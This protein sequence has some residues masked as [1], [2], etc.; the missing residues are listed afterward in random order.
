MKKTIFISTV[1]VTFLVLALAVTAVI[2][3]TQ[4]SLTSLDNGWFWGPVTSVADANNL[5]EQVVVLEGKVGTQTNVSWNE[6]SFSDSTG[7]TTLDFEDWITSDGIPQNVTVRVI[8]EAE[9]GKIDVFGLQTQGT[10]TATADTTA[11]QI[12]SGSKED[13]N[14]VLQGQIGEK[15]DDPGYWESWMWYEFTDSSGTT[16]VDLENKLSENQVPQNQT[17]LLYGSGDD[18]YGDPKVNIDYILLIGGGE[19]PPTATET[20]P[21]PPPTAT[22]T[23]QPGGDWFWEK[24]HTVS[25]AC[26]LDQMVAVVEGQV[27]NRTNVSWNEWTFSDSSGSLTLDFEDWIPTAAIPQNTTV[28]IIGKAQDCKLD[29]WGLQTQGKVFVQPDT[30]AAQINTGNYKNQEV[31]LMGQIGDQNSTNFPSSWN[32]YNFADSSGIT[33]TDLENDLTAS[34]IPQHLTMLLFGEGNDYFGDPKVDSDY[35]LLAATDQPVPTATPTATNTLPGPA[36]TA[37][38]TPV[39]GEVNDLNLPIVVS[40]F[41]ALPPALPTKTPIPTPTT[42]PTGW[43]WGPVTTVSQLLSGCCHEQVVVVQG[44]IGNQTDVPWNEWSFSDGTGTFTLD[45]E[46]EIPKVAIPRDTTVQIIGR[47]E[48]NQ[49]GIEKIDVYGLQTKGNVSATADTT[50]Q[51]VESGSKD[52]QFIA[53]EGQFGTQDYGP[54]MWYNFSDST[55]TTIADLENALTDSQIPKNQT[56]LLYGQGDEDF[57]QNKINAK[58]MLFAANIK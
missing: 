22:N 31:I 9:N 5:D 43:L 48:T 28:H 6:W 13:Q 26:S 39:P 8:G 44:Q 12:N 21:G 20:Q 4:S 58:L 36:P 34:Q 41:G 35:M 2:A 18:Y 51:Q 53:V 11:A 47:V 23:A 16:K 32:V 37:T 38:N 49:R 24:T 30:T 54:W 7:T 55:G 14:V 10:V 27:G 56:L 33:L 52:G 3:V 19:P 40:K 46:D 1:L 50:V 15:L 57:G 45:F 42:S 29:V 17:V 25:Q